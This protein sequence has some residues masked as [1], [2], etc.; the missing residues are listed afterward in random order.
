LRQLGDPLHD[1]APQDLADR[2]RAG[3]RQAET[4]LVRRYSRPIMTLLR[5]RTGN[6]QRAED[7]HQDTFFVVLQR[8]RTSGIDDPAH[9]S[10]FLHQTAI[11]LLIG[12]NRREARRKTQPDLDLIDIQPDASADQLRTL[13]REEADGAVRA[14]IQE[15]NT[16]RDKELLYRFYIL[17][18][19]K[20][21]ICKAMA[22]SVEGFDHVISRARRRFRE[23]IVQKNPSADL[24]ETD[25]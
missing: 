3:D 24:L 11:N 9:V 17:Q 25:R 21:L 20:P 12:D 16:P 22:L 15:M 5:H 4:E 1:V 2:I 23:L 10:A 7:L 8:L 19:E 6:V 18:Q 14:M 13:I